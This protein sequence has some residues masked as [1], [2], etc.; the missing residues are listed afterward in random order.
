MWP[1]IVAWVI[2]KAWPAILHALQRFWSVL[3]IGLIILACWLWWRG[4]IAKVRSISCK[5]CISDYTA[6]HP[7]NTIQS[8]GTVTY[9]TYTDKGGFLDL[10][11]WRIIRIVIVPAK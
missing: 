2:G 9:N 1:E 3:V 4:Y 7:T 11:F 5:Q 8:G 6:T 10:R